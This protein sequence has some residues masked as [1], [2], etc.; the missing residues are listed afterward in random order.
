MQ[1]PRTLVAYYR[2]STNQQ[3]ASGLGLEGQKAC[4][5]AYAAVT[6]ARLLTSY[7][8]VESGCKTDRPMLDKAI[9]H[10]NC[11]GA[12]LIIAKLDRLARNVHFLSGL[13]ESGS[14][15]SR[16]TTRT[17]IVSPFT[18]SPPSPRTRRGVSRSARRPRWPPTRPAAGSSAR[19]Q[20]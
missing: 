1:P 18:F 17:P 7:Q 19:P 4:V 9:A 3:G 13:M 16:A 8:E 20:T 6:R 10:A 12:A 11:S 15:S 2:V 14:T 5:E